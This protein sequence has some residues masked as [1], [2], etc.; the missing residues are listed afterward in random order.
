MSTLDTQHGR[1]AT[2]IAERRAGFAR[3]CVSRVNLSVHWYAKPQELLYRGA[4]AVAL[5]DHYTRQG[6]SVGITAFDCGQRLTRWM[7]THVLEVALK[8]PSEPLDLPMLAL[9]LA[10]L[11]FFRLVVISAL[12]RLAPHQVR[13]GL[14]QVG[15]LPD[16][17]RA[18]FDAVLD[19][20]VRS[21]DDAVRFIRRFAEQEVQR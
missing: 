21:K 18:G 17:W 13:N 5:A 16:G 14:S 9:A 20:D 19:S 3:R 2:G 12:I 11:A 4:A 10:E 1:F 15:T 7:G 6:C 8:R